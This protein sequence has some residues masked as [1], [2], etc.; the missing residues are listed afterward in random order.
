MT[1]EGREIQDSE[2]PRKE[3][4]P[5]GR[6]RPTVSIAAVMSNKMKGKN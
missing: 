5:E 6:S 4:L 3:V 2:R 1:S